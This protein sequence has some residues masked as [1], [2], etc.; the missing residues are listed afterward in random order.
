M[1][2]MMTAEELDR[3]ESESAELVKAS[4]NI[5]AVLAAG[6][7]RRLITEIRSLRKRVEELER[8][9]EWWASIARDYKHDLGEYMRR[10]PA[11]LAWEMVSHKQIDAAWS[12][13]E[14]YFRA[15]IGTGAGLRVLEQLGIVRCEECGGVG[16]C[17]VDDDQD[18]GGS[19]DAVC[20]TCNGHGWVVEDE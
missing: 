11:G 1:N 17:H 6:Q 18:A 7:I 19:Y 5:G 15:S 10:G 8:D 13:A 12:V 20:P 4:P 14:R 9:R 3:V 16:G 2:E